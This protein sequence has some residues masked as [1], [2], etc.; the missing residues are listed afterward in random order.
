MKIWSISDT[1]FSS[2]EDFS[3]EIFGEIWKDHQ[4]KIK[5]NWSTLVG[6][7]DVVVV[8]GDISWEKKP[9]KALLH[10]K[11]INDLPGKLKILIKG[12]HDHWWKGLDKL[13][14]QLPKGMIALQGTATKVDGQVICGTRGWL[15]PNDPYFD[16]LD[17]KTYNKELGLLKAALEEAMTL[18]PIEGIHVFTHFPVFT[19]EG[20]T[21]AFYELLKEYPVRTI[22][23]GHFHMKKEWKKIPKGMQDGMNCR[24]TASDFVDHKPELIWQD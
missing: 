20:A 11:E 23:Y 3:M 18:D 12:N 4:R 19:S 5:K 17:H 1:H 9:D 10:L 2:R 7:M 16:A 21:T 8:G 22:T 24:L 13:N 6:H 15:S 14:A